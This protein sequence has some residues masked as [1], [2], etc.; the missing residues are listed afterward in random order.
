MYGFD[1]SSPTRAQNCS[2]GRGCQPNQWSKHCA[3]V[4]TTR[5]A[6]TPWSPV[7]SSFCVS[8]QTVTRSGTTRSSC[9]L[10]RLSQLATQ[11]A[12]GTPVAA[13]QR[14]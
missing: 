11:I 12:V 8:F 4:D 13:A 9:L 5:S 2:R 6:G 1:G 7:A 10:D 14:A 3:P